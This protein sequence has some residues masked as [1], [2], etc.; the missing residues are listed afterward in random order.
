MT[1]EELKAANLARWQKMQITPAALPTVDKVCY[2]LLAYA[3]RYQTVA[4]DVWANAALWPVVATIAERESGADFSKSLAQGDPWDE[5]STHVPV[6]I[7]PFASWEAAAV[8]AI[9]HDDAIDKFS[10][11]AIAD[12]LTQIQQYNGLGHDDQPSPYIWSMSDQYVKGGYSSDGHWDPNYVSE[13]VGVAAMLA[14][15]KA[16]D[17]A[18]GF[19][20]DTS[21]L[22]ATHP[23]NAPATSF[24]NA[25]NAPAPPPPAAPSGEPIT[26][27][28]I[29]SDLNRLGVKPQLVVDGI[30][31]RDTKAAVRAFQIIHALK[32]D[33]KAHALTLSDLAAAAA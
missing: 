13:Q 28:Q 4:K 2:Q 12:V 26:T 32:A 17:A 18:A 21:Q 5:R 24:E 25:L 10:D 11:M 19:W 33:G 15:L 16:L 27:R 7:G 1:L 30:Y 14:R 3:S 23:I 20:T 29:Q 6:G 9:K 31:G 22:A 8:W